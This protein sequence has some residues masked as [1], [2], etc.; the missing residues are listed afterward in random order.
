MYV[1]KWR[2]YY[3]DYTMSVIL[4]GYSNDTVVDSVTSHFGLW[5]HLTCF[6]SYAVDIKY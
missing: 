4:I 3:T 1:F 2:Y 5:R 6:F